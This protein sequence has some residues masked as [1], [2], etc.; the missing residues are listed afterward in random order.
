[1]H[2]HGIR[3]ML[4][5]IVMA[6][7][8]AGMFFLRFW[9]KTGDRLFGLFALSFWILAIN[10]TVVAFT[11]RDEPLRT[12]SYVVRLGAFVLILLAIV[13]K[14]RARVADKR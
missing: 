14:N 11:E 1:M 12:A 7:V 10:W 13:D 9:R 6:C 8:V 3:F 4:G 2:E 5:A